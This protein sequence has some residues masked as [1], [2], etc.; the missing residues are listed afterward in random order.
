MSKQVQHFIAL[1][2]TGLQICRGLGVTLDSSANPEASQRLINEL[3]RM[4]ARAAE[5]QA[6]NEVRLLIRDHIAFARELDEADRTDWIAC[7][8]N[9]F[10]F[11]RLTRSGAEIQLDLVVDTHNGAGAQIHNNIPILLDNQSWRKR[12]TFH[13]ADIDV[14]EH[15]TAR[16]EIGSLLMDF[17]NTG[18][19]FV[20]CRRGAGPLQSH[21][22]E[23]GNP[24]DPRYRE[25]PPGERN[26]LRSSMIALRVSPNELET[27]W[28][29]LSRRAEELIRENPLATYLYAPKKYVRYWPEHLR[30]TEPTLQFRGIVGQR[31]GLYPVLK[32]LE[33]TLEQMLQQ[34]LAS[35]TNPHGTSHAPE[36]Y[37]QI[38]RLMTTYP[39]TWRQADR[40]VF[41]C[42]LQ[43]VA[44][45]LFSQDEQHQS[46]FQVELVCSEP[47]AVAA[48]V[49]WETFFHFGTRNLPLAASFLGNPHGAPGLRLLVVDIG[50]GSTDIAHVD[51]HWQ[52]RADDESVDVTFRLLESM[53][54]TRAGDRLSHIIATAILVFIQQKYAVTEP[55]DLK[56][57]SAN[58]GFTRAYK[59]LIV[60]RI[61]ELAEAAKIALAGPEGVW[62]LEA[63]S[64]YDLLR[65][66]E[67]LL[68][69]VALE[70]HIQQGP[71]LMLNR[72]V[73]RAWVEADRQSLET[74]NE[75][76]FMDIFFY[77]EELMDSLRTD[78]REPHAVILSGRSTRLSFI[79][80]MVVKSLRLPPHRIRTLDHLLPAAARLQS[81]G[82][83]DKLA[84]VYGAQRFRFGDHIR[85]EMLADEPVFTRH[86]GTVRETPAGLKLNKVIVNAGAHCPQTVA[87]TVE[88]GR[89]L[90]IGHA[91][92]KDGRAEL[93]AN[94]SNRSQTQHHT[95]DLEITDDF[96]LRLREPNADVALSEWV[97]GGAD[98]IVDNFNDTGRI[99]G[100]PEG[101]L[102]R[103]VLKNQDRWL[104]H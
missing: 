15:R 96:S 66:F 2:N 3:W 68:A 28:L 89:D 88:A 60:S 31:V 75:P 65:G 77:L 56:V 40:T 22:V 84:V 16:N 14:A 81:N 103:I 100:E 52:T 11:F 62:R 10:V 67:P 55:L 36:F 93:I 61:S 70:D 25:R 38:T 48:Y 58:P 76:G 69:N 94:L 95:V 1:P 46:Q 74:H 73:L 20:F 86:I 13:L 4:A 51:I 8:P 45:R 12:K 97:P 63:D 87:V 27:P 30:A 24:F 78:H 19:A 80:D 72:E 98:L 6:D 90:R 41:Q 49:L 59:R 79:K 32:I 50:G 34:V 57:E 42:L 102:K 21:I 33:H 54:F 47:V 17:G 92:R 26:I 23:P 104:K 39:L 71:H 44:N 43:R 91:F 85:F 7:D 99:D 9:D 5:R 83:L 18:S 35:I 29:I 82:N 37:P 101:L 64:E 53:R